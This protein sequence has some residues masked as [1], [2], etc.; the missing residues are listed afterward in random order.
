MG[1]LV[2]ETNNKNF[3]VDYDRD[4]NLYSVVYFKDYKFVDMCQF[5]PYVGASE[6]KHVYIVYGDRVDYNDNIIEHWVEVI[7][8]NAEQADACAEY[9]NF[10]NEQSGVVYWS[11]ACGLPIDEGDYIK[12]S[13]E[14]K[15]NR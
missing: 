1:A 13:K 2:P 8:D 4:N 9:L 6:V 7:L 11:G 3:T 12:K 14:L 5:V 15:K 10:T